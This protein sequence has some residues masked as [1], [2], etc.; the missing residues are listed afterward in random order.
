VGQTQYVRLADIKGVR[1]D[2]NF[3]ANYING[4]YGSVPSIG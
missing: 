1:R 2:E 4:I 3:F